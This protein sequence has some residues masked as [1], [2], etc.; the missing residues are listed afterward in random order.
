MSELSNFVLGAFRQVGGLI[1]PPSY[2]FYEVLLPEDVAHQWGVP[3]YQRLGFSDDPPP[4]AA[5]QLVSEGAGTILGYGHPLV[6]TLVEALRADPACTRVYINNVRLDK[7]GLFELAHEMFTFP[8]AYLSKTKLGSV[9]ARLCHYVRFNFKAALITDEKRE[10]LVSI[11]MDAQSGLPVPGLLEEEGL[12]RLEDRPAFEHLA[13]APVRWLP[14][15]QDALSPPVLEGLLERANRAAVDGLAEALKSLRRRAAR[16]LDLDRARLTEYYDGIMRDLEQ[17]IERTTSDARRASLED[18][19]VAARAEREAKLDDVEA[20]YRLRVELELINLQ[21]I[22]QPKVILPVHV[23]DREVTVDRVVV[24]DPLL[25]RVEPWACDVCGRSATRLMLCSGGH[26]VHEDCLLPTQCVD[27]KRV[28]CRQ[29]A[30]QIDE[31][32]VCHRPVC[33][34]SLNRCSA[35]GRGT[36]HDHVGLCHAADGQPAVLPSSQ[37]EP[38]PEEEEA[39]AGAKAKQK[40]KAQPESAGT[41]EAAASVSAPPRREARKQEEK[42]PARKAKSRKASR[43]PRPDLGPKPYKIEVYVEPRA[44]VVNAFVLTKGR[45]QIA[46]RSWELTDRGILVHCRCNKWY[47]CPAHGQVLEPAEP[48]EIESQIEEQIEALRQE[49]GISSRQVFRYAVVRRANR[50][51]TR[52]VLRGAWR[53]EG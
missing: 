5:D 16:H 31:C 8:N 27:C 29:C 43:P 3:A 1:D 35:C 7:R 26:L 47:E 49:Y 14:G 38:E 32:V 18:K 52:V 46:V 48:S 51:V 24:W 25:H 53:D 6:E 17:R 41:D 42:K 11:V 19:L 9:A 10:R 23:E 2:G 28:Y 13:P 33:R 36:C 40:Q 34:R 45:K 37:P 22:V 21:V 39:A 50:P 20:K 15:H 12:I 4:E 30:D 44:P